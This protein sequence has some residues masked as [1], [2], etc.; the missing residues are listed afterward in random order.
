MQ[1]PSVLL[2][3]FFELTTEQIRR[4]KEASSS[5]K[6]FAAK[7]VHEI[8]PQEVLTSSNVNGRKG[9]SK[10]DPEK[11]STVRQIVYTYWPLKPGA[12]EEKD[13]ASKCTKAIDEAGRR[14]NRKK[15]KKKKKNKGDST[16]VSSSD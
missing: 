11:M 8:F 7:L 1:P 2:P 4:I 6:N 5:R 13:W 3:S 9:K 16:S 14:L 12:C 15:M 10:L